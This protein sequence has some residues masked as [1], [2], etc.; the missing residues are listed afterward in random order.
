M[1]HE[2]EQLSPFILLELSTKLEIISI[3]RTPIEYKES[4]FISKTYTD[5]LSP[6]AAEI[7]INYANQLKESN[8][9]Q[10]FIYD[11]PA[12][13]FEIH[14]YQAHLHLSNNNET[15]FLS[16]MDIQAN[17]CTIDSK[18]LKNL[19]LEN[20]TLTARIDDLEKKFELQQRHYDIFVDQAPIAMYDIDLESRILTGNQRALEFFHLKGT[21]DFKKHFIFE[22][23]HEKD[24][25]S[26]EEKFTLACEGTEQYF[27]FESPHDEFQ[28]FKSCFIPVY[29]FQ[30]FVY[31]VFS[32]TEDVT[33]E[34]LAEQILKKKNSSLAKEVKRKTEESR[35]KDEV[36]FEQ[37]R[38][39]QMA[40]LIKMIA[41]QWRQPLSLISTVSGNV[42]VMTDLGSI[43]KKSLKASM[44]TINVQAQE[45]SK[46]ISD[47]D[48][49]YKPKT[50]KTQLQLKDLGDGVMDVIQESLKEDG[51]E[52]RRISDTNRTFSTYKN[53]I[54]QV[55]INLI[56]NA[57]EILLQRKIKNPRITLRGYETDKYQCIEVVDNAEG[58]PEEIMGQIF[59]PYFS[60]KIGKN[61]TGLGLHMAKTMIESHCDGILSVKNE[62]YGAN[63]TIMLP[64]N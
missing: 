40:Q 39:V 25:E 9:P 59:D 37:S 61:G 23:V 31:K 55:M 56:E 45:L 12:D 7:F 52:F 57:H 48:D 32:L 13:H 50:T 64:N 6:K 43:D 36:I 5:F 22:F 41:H 49:F 58:I 28:M 30:N 35:E 8:Q 21:F 42:E 53:E 11:A 1:K 10:T 33:K 14:P 47:F 34:Y 29:D 51:I 44:R 3:S 26:L 17:S 27:T 2:K 4:D 18:E 38:H 24:R 62:T 20:A 16:L 60:T 63:F 15:L 19:E 46:I 54:I